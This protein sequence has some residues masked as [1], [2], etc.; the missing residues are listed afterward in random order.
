MLSKNPFSKELDRLDENFLDP[1]VRLAVLQTFKNLFDEKKEAIDKS[2]SLFG[3]V[4][5]YRETISETVRECVDTVLK[6]FEKF[7]DSR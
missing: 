1:N 5:E 6:G 4:E 3:S 2:F 7:G